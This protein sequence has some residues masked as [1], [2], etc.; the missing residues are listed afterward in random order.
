[1]RPTDRYAIAIA[2]SVVLAS[3]T[4]SPLTA[5][6]SYLGASWLLI[7]G[8]CLIGALARR[9]PLGSPG[10]LV[11]QLL[12]ITGYLF[13]LSGRAAEV[14]QLGF[15]RRIVELLASAGEH[16]R[17][18]AAPMSA[19]AGVSLLFIGS[20]G[21]ITVI[22][23]LLVITAAKPA[24]GLAPPLTVFLVPAIGLGT[25]I[26][27]RAF[28]CI[29]VGYL[30]I[31][32]AE[33]MNTN[34]RWTRGLSKDSAGG[35][36][37]EQ[38]RAVVWRAAAYIAVPALALSLVAGSALPTLALSGWGFGEGNAGNG[39]LRLSDPTLDLKRNLTLPANRVVLTYRTNKPTGQY[40][41]MAS[42]PS[43]SDA[44]WRNAQTTIDQGNR[45]PQPPG[46]T[47]PTGKDRKTT[48]TIKNLDSEYLPL[49]FAPRSFEAAGQWGY[50]P[51]SLVVIA[52]DRDQDRTQAT[53]DLTYT[54]DSRDIIPNPQTLAGIV[55]GDPP[56]ANLTT[57]VPAD[58]PNNI[59]QLARRITVG[60]D[61]PAEK[62]AAIQA[63]LRNSDNFTYS[64]DPRPGS[65]YQA[66]E[67][68]LFRDRHG[69]CEQFAASMAILA[70]IVGIPSRVAVGFLPGTRNGDVWTVTARDSH[71]WPE[72]YFSG[73]GWV[74]YEP[75]P[76]SVTG[77]APAWSIAQSV[78]A[79]Q[80]SAPATNSQ[81]PST[82]ARP[83]NRAEEQAAHQSAGTT[84]QQPSF[85]W[86]K[87]LGFGGGGLLLLA[88]LAAPATIRI[89]RRR[90]RLGGGIADP[91]DRIEA[92]WAE[93]RD[94]VR[95]LRRPWPK[96]SPRA[97]AGQVS[98]HA[99]DSA[100]E[101]LA[102]L[103]VLVERERYARTFTDAAAAA[104][105]APLVRSVRQGL[106][107]DR[108]RRARAA[109]TLL[110]RSVFRRGS[111]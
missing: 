77:S 61:S 108:S 43:F 84:A 26:G 54:V 56:D 86:V 73:Y 7:L 69:Y 40:L 83:R 70:R 48:I 67:N 15:G 20:L 17:T 88:L 74:R 60:A 91:A 23:D 75:T 105:V 89:G 109:I 59:R 98:R 29:G 38:T 78:P 11:A 21:L 24:L 6:P 65:G 53:H 30:A 94:T 14:A 16:M 4:L 51:N 111:S 71:A 81:V 95:D 9:T 25:D 101:A 100:K 57:A 104:A 79:S 49:P 93:V 99:D 103:A 107:Q 85:P 45:L 80:E 52:S 55:T 76:S 46:L 39:P 66:L 97:I 31:L 22:T 27:V 63:Y 68:F 32:I 41:R 1:M 110:P 10:T 44:G 37:P 47:A 35:S 102:E 12:A 33:G 28:L 58:L 13:W 92:G 90:A 18:E 87:V 64:T 5:D 2:V 36:M 19:N 62:A 72:L 34:A 42:L 106:L 82:E 8:I 50:D 3:F 96:A